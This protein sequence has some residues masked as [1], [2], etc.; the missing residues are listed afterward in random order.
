MDSSTK[1][2]KET[3]SCSVCWGI[4]KIQKRDRTLHKHG[5][6]GSE[7]K[8]CPGSYKPP[9][10]SSAAVHGATKADVRSISSTAAR[11][12]PSNTGNVQMRN[13][14]T[15]SLPSTSSK[16]NSQP[17]D[18][19][20]QQPEWSRLMTRIPKAARFQCATSFVKL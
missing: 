11:S 14:V 9:A 19:C 3:G 13:I 5:H 17:D 2:S 20:L 15:S 16:A 18:L 1:S 6:G 10:T 8:C 12:K 4:F 7:D